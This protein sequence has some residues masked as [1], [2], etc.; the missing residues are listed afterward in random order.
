MEK[1]ILYPA[2]FSLE[3][4]TKNTYNVT[5]P[6]FDNCF[7]FGEGLSH[8]NY[9]AMDVLALII[10]DMESNNKEI[11]DPDIT[12]AIEV[13]EEEKVIFIPVD[14]ELVDKYKS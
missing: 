12:P 14:R 7:T 13:K 9:M 4:G 11:P 10:A 2:I 8:A 6:H 5:F 3:Q 1:I